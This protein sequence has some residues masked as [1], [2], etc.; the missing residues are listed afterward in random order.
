LASIGASSYRFRGLSATRLVDCNSEQRVGCRPAG[1]HD[2]RE[3]AI[4]AFDTV[5]WTVKFGVI[6]LLQPLLLAV[7]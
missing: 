4:A 6:V 2:R 1:L 7:L 5:H 3:A